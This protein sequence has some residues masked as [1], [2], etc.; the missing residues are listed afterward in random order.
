MQRACFLLSVCA[1]RCSFSKERAVPFLT[2]VTTAEIPN[3]LFLF[4]FQVPAKK[5]QVEP[6]LVGLLQMVLF[7][8]FQGEAA[9]FIL[10]PCSHKDASYFLIC[11][12]PQGLVLK[13]RCMAK[14]TFSLPGVMGQRKMLA[15]T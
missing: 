10:L 8:V 1:G 13:G 12:A 6:R 15:V 7:Q 4:F 11:A 2:F 5:I 14:Q 3:G 9:V